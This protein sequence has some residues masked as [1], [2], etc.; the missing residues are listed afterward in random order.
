MAQN[1]HTL[2]NSRFDLVQVGNF[3]VGGCDNE[4]RGTVVKE[5]VLAESLTTPALQ[6]SVTL[7]SQIYQPPGKFL[8][9]FK[10]KNISFDLRYQSGY[11]GD[12][13]VNQKVYRMDNRDLMPINVGQ[14]QEFTLHACDQTLL[15]DAKA[16]VSK[17]WK[18]TPP[19]DIVNYVLKS[20]VGAD[21]VDVEKCGPARDYIAENIHP[22]QVIN[23]QSNVA[24]ADNQDPSFVH[25]MTYD[26]LNSVG[27]HH[28]R[29]LKTMIKGQPS[30]TFKHSETGPAGEGKYQNKLAAISHSFPCDFDLLSD[31]L[32]GIDENGQNMNSLSTVNPANKAFS[33]L[34]NKT[35][36]C[37]IGGF[38]YK[39]S[40]TNYGTA[41]QQNSCN[42]DVEHHLLLR[43][44]RMSLLERDK[45][46]LRMVVPW[47]PGLHVGMVIALEW[48]DKQNGQPV[49]G[50]GNYLIAS[51]MHTIKL[52]GFSTTTID[53]VAQTALKGS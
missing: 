10:N 30:Y 22:F 7:Q 31:I 33:L 47:N 11:G 23:Q 34:G 50:Y 51:M 53:C 49:Y 38:N 12:F 8:G 14:T 25:Y 29:S 21:K 9:N 15:N 52:G 2:K 48:K 35:Q 41:Q 6:T 32:N 17:S 26:G 24:L 28:F 19:S 4:L 1:L 20:C 37:G 45:V 13:S 44:A 43:Q 42:T 40:T 18:C 3:D 36:G 46:A 16:L 5:I 27:I 39:S